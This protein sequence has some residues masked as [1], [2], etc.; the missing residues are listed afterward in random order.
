MQ[1]TDYCRKKQFFLAEKEI[2]MEKEKYESLELEII[3]FDSDDIVTDSW[4]LP[5]H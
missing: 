3:V 4:E 2:I 1:V 5:D